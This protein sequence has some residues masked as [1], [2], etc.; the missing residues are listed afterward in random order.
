MLV[1]VLVMT[2]VEVGK[3]CYRANLKKPHGA[4]LPTN[5]A[6]YCMF[7]LK[8]QICA[9]MAASVMHVKYGPLALHTDV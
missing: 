2:A 6:H 4:N 7:H 5:G 8:L 9:N 1:W 3:T